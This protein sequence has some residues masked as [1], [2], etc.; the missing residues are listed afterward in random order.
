MGAKMA[1]N[2]EIVK[3]DSGMALTQQSGLHND[4]PINLTKLTMN[5]LNFIGK[6]MAASGAFKDIQTQSAALVRI[7]AGQEM[8]LGPFAAMSNINIIEG[9][10]SVGGHIMAAR[11]K[12]SKKY[13]YKIM[14]WEKDG[15][16]IDLYEDGKKIGNSEFLVIDAQN[17]ELLDPTCKFP[18]HNVREIKFYNKWKKQ[19]ETKQGCNCKENWK[20]YPRNMFFN[21][22]ISNGVRIYCPD[23]LG[24]AP[25]YDPDELGA[26]TDEL[27]RVTELPASAI[28][29]VQQLPQGSD[30]QPAPAYDEEA[31]ANRD[32]D[33]TKEQETDRTGN[34]LQLISDQLQERG[35]EDKAQRGIIALHIANVA[36]FGDLNKGQWF[37][38]YDQITDMDDETLGSFAIEPEEDEPVDDPKPPKV[39]DEVITDV[40]DEALANGTLLDGVAD[41]FGPGTEDVTPKSSVVAKPSGRQL[42]KV[43]SLFIKKKLKEDEQQQAFAMEAIGKNYAVTPDDFD[44]LITALER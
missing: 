4:K 17:A 33:T 2:S 20:R 26:S 3:Q 19:S 7:L 8:G 31:A 18:N 29:A 22:A 40:D 39:L 36:G 13:D 27:G 43:R 25:V 11:V 12:A 9:N 30:E 15:C 41:V 1:E 35:I 23:V 38:I 24:N 5:E 32:I 44:K 28:P 21:R 42:A 37:D 10:A 16:S 6:A 34:P 14:K